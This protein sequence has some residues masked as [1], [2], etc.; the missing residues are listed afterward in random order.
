[1]IA[2]APGPDVRLATRTSPASGLLGAWVILPTGSCEAHGPH[3]PLDTDCRISEGMAVRAARR[4][5]ASGRNAV[6]LPTLPYGVTH[7][8]G[9]FPGTLSVPAAIVT[10]TVVALLTGALESGAVGVAIA[11]SHFEP[12]HIDALFAAVTRLRHIPEARVVYPNVASRRYA[13][14]LGAEFVSGACHAGAYETSLVLA[15]APELVDEGARAG[16]PEVPID[17]AAAMRAGATTFAEAGGV[18]AYFGAPLAGTALD[19]E[20]WLDTLA[21]ILVEAIEAG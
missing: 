4:L 16:L 1:M 17:L 20:R 10:D 7:Y 12:A 2:A 11:N 18:D 9:D 21:E 5:V 15:M 3:L 14:R 19:G 6:V 8:A 13:I